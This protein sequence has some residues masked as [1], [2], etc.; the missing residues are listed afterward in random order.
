MSTLGRFV[1][2]VWLFVVL[3]INSSYTANLTSIFTVQLATSSI[4]G[5]DSLISSN[6]HIGFQVGSFA[7]SYLSEQLNVQ[8]SRLIALGS[9]EEYAAALKNGTVGAIV[10]EQPYIDLF[11]TEYCDYLIR[12]QQFTKS[13]WGFVSISQTKL[14]SFHLLGFDK[15][16]FT[17]FFLLRYDINLILELCL[18][19]FQSLIVGN[20]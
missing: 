19:Y 1:I 2:V 9:P 6:V 8:K 20:Y 13:G 4:T 17:K 14:S 18:C 7:E 10:D 16:C 15:F 11:L 5:I 12:G 3:I